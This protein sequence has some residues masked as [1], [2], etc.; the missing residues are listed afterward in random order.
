MSRF[1]GVPELPPDMSEWELRVLSAL[2]QNIELLI[3]ARGEVDSASKALVRSDISVRSSITPQFQALSARGA[4]ITVSGVAIPTLDD[5]TAL[6]QDFIKLSQ[7]VATLRNTL[8]TLITQ[9]RGS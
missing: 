7:D 9:L 2:K 8:S 6:L 4:G 5:Y 3:G 1:T